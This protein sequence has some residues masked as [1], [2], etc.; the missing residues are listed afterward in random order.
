MNLYNFITH[1]EIETVSES[2]ERES[3]FKINKNHK[4]YEL[5]ISN[6]KAGVD[7]YDGTK[8]GDYIILIGLQTS[9]R[10]WGAPVTGKE[11]K[12]LQDTNNLKKYIDKRLGKSRI[13]GYGT[14]D[15]GQ[16]SL[17]E[18]II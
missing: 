2:I 5:S 7:F 6:G 17:F 15:E 3:D 9:T 11:L 12:E 18:M 8:K 14:M 16:I 10:G 4:G 13:N 1:K